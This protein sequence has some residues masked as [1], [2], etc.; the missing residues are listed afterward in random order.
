MNYFLGIDATDRRARGRLRGHRPTGREPPG[1]GHDRDHAATSGTTPRRP[2]TRTDTWRL[3]LDGAL[4]GTPRPS[5]AFTPRADSIQHAAL[6][7]AMTS[8]GASPRRLLRRARSTRSGSG[9]SPAAARRSWP[10][11]DHYLHER[12]RPDRPL[13]PRRG[14][15][16]PPPPRASPAHPPAR[17]ANGPTWTAGPP[18]TPAAAQATARP[19]VDTVTIAPTT[20]TTGQTL[21]ATVTSHDAEGDPLTTSYQWTRERHSTSRAPPARRSTSPPPATATT[22]T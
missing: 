12:H 11:R 21:T 7:T 18:L 22:A 5:A 9:T 3:Y 14:H 19:V 4:D 2:T 8:T 13:R 16:A 20:P 10:Q 15:A 1:H 6:G 17:S